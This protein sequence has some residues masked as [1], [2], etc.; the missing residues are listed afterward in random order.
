MDKEVAEYALKRCPTL[1]R[2]YLSC[3]VG[4]NVLGRKDIAPDGM[5]RTEWAIYNMLCAMEELT[6]HMIEKEVDDLWS[7]WASNR[8]K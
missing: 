8:S 3:G 2:A 6:E 4:K 5:T 1:Y 7:D